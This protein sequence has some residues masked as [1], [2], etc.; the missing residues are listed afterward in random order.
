MKIYLCE[1]GQT[2]LCTNKHIIFA[3]IMCIA[4][5]WTYVIRIYW[6]TACIVGRCVLLCVLWIQQS[7]LFNVKFSLRS[8]WK[9][10][11]R[12]RKKI[13]K[14]WVDK[15]HYKLDDIKFV[16]IDFDTRNELNHLMY[17]LICFVDC[18]CVCVSVRA[19]ASASFCVWYF[20]AFNSV[21][22]ATIP[23]MR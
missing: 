1:C 9:R 11:R 3:K 2:S 21:C 14:M 5:T 15:F 16:S 18:V 8:V 19:W 7:P 4:Y 13:T 17:Y 6:N 10:M 20:G 22:L 23:Y 12:G